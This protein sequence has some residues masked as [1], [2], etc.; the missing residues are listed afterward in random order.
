MTWRSLR[1][2]IPIAV[3][4]GIWQLVG[5]T[6]SLTAPPPSTWWTAFRGI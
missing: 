5:N 1:G 2:L 6:S 3:L 4:L